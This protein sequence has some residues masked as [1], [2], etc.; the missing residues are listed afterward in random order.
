MSVRATVI[1]PARLAST[2]FPG[3]VLANAT[4]RPLIQHVFERAQ[5]SA[6]AAR[7]VVATDEARVADAVAG[8]GGEVVMTSR[9]HPNGTSRLA[10]AAGVLGL[11]DDE[12]VVNAQ[13]D[14]PELDPS[15]L[16]AAVGA[17]VQPRARAASVGTV[18]APITTWADASN[19]AVVK[20]V[21]RLDGTAL[22]F[23]RA[24]IPHARDGAPGRMPEMLRHIG[25]YV[26]RRAF[27]REYAALAPTPLEKVE[28]LEQLR[29]LEHG[30]DIGVAVAASAGP[31]GIDT[32]EQ[33]EAFVRRWRER[34]GGARGG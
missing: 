30:Y 8:F 9:D 12:I 33:Y 15:H 5:R 25:T 7:V 19:P 3:K 17:L 16:D 29:V 11:A 10:E 13:G 20:V 14:E 6:C 18:A 1:I 23:S 2:R 26:Y 28:Q 24:P 22:V 27:L 31:P 4:G 32:P 21:C 34:A